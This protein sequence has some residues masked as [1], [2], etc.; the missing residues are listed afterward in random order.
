VEEYEVHRLLIVEVSFVGR[1][2]GLS[3]ARKFVEIFGFTAD[4]S[5]MS[6]IQS[7]S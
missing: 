5:K 1:F 4:A 3:P 6:D 2:V 7:V